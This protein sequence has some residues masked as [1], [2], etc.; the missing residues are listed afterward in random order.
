MKIKTTTDIF[1]EKANI[2]HGNLYSYTNTNYIKSN[3]KLVITCP[4]HGD[5]MQTPNN[6]LAKKGCPKCGV[7]IAA[8][9]HMY[10]TEDFIKKASEVHG[11]SYTYN[12]VC[13]L[14]AHTKVII[15]CI[16]HGD[17]TQK[18]GEH[19]HGHGCNKCGEES[20]GGYSK[21]EWVRK[22]KN[23]TA[24]FYI[25]RCFN[26]DEEFY[27]VGITVKSIKV[28]YSGL[29]RMPYAYEVVSEIRGGGWFHLGFR[30]RR[31]NKVKR[32]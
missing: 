32:I 12:K 6:H 24:T 17:F 19:L 7:I 10:T 23:R 26:K 9:S 20:K 3:Q 29:K 25:L 30:K 31:K 13:Y 15:T 5:F 1:V 4:L 14:E 22:V 27:K 16:K 21:A 11:D 28:R 18:P 8:K 2:K